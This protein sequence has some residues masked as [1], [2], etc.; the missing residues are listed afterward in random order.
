MAKNWRRS[1]SEETVRG[2]QERGDTQ[3]ARDR[4]RREM[5]Y[6]QSDIGRGEG[7]FTSF[8]TSSC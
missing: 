8:V 1:V 4:I 2:P 6:F 7:G 5:A 3:R